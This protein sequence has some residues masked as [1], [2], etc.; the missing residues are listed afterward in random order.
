[1]QGKH[2]AEMVLA[3]HE[4]DDYFAVP[5]P[6]PVVPLAVPP[7]DVPLVPAPA[8]VVPLWLLVPLAAGVPLDPPPRLQPPS[9]KTNATA[10]SAT[11]TPFEDVFIILPFL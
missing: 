8:P 2:G 6:L 4:P 3:V 5:V 9:T 11:R 7:E 1:M 10:E